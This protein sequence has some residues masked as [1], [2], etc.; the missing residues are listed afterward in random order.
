MSTQMQNISNTVVVSNDKKDEPT[1]QSSVVFALTRLTEQRKQWETTVYRAS[2]ES[3]YSILQSCY[4][5]EWSMAGNDANAKA[6][7]EG[8]RHFAAQHGFSFKDST[9]M[10]N[11][12]VRCVFGDVARS[13]VSTYSLVLRE[14]KKRNVGVN[15]IPAFISDNGGVEQI[16]LSKS[17]NY[18][19]AKQKAEL[20]VDAATKNVL[21]VVSSK[22]LSE[23]ATSEHM[24]ERCVLIAKQQAD[25]TFAVTAVV[26][27]KSA[28]TAALVSHYGSTKA[29]SA[30][31]AVKQ[32]AANDDDAR[33]QIL[34]EIANAL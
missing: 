27:G 22:L 29:D 31:T 3:L 2:N 16:R 19:T 26:R 28:L 18:K 30:D 5:I 15:D 21:G 9:P 34:R 8:L 4:A 33:S 24:G 7:R 25:G 17:P 13:R 12:V 14:A 6:R 32:E 11:R 20:A 10:M 23:L 1:L